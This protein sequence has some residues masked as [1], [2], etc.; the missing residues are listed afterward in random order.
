MKKEYFRH[1][2]LCTLA[3]LCVFSCNVNAAEQLTKFM[4]PNNQIQAMGI[5][6]MTLESNSESVEVS[7]PAQVVVPPTA[8]QVVSSPVAGLVTQ[9]L[10]QPNQVVSAGAPLL[11][12][13]SGL[14]PF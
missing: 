14:H 9:L 5:K 3:I 2:G 6:T 4:V 7:F 11:K 12:M 13:I 1:F 10:V 8:E